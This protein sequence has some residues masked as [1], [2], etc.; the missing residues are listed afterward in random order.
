MQ[1]ES[2]PLVYKAYFIDKSSLPIVS[3]S[4]ELNFATLFYFLVVLQLPLIPVYGYD[5][6]VVRPRLNLMN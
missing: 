5:A 4:I 6:S 1:A 2:T 3:Y